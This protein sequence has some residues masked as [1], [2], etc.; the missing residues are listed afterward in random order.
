MHRN[1]F[2]YFVKKKVLFFLSK[3]IIFLN[4]MLIN[5]GKNNIIIIFF[6]INK[7]FTDI[8]NRII[9]NS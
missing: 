1:N 5:L 4:N 7:Y 3:I 6:K 2:L 9:N 8:V